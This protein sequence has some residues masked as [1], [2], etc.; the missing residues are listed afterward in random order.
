[1]AVDGAAVAGRLAGSLPFATVSFYDRS[2][3][4]AEAFGG[5][6][7]YLEETYPRVHAR[8]SREQVADLSLLYTWQGRDRSLRPALL[9]AH[10]DVVPVE[11]ASS[12][13]WVHP[14]F[15]GTIAEGFVWG[16]GALD[17]KVDVVCIL[18]AVE[19]LLAEG[20]TP[21]RTIY[22]SFG[23]DEEVGGHE[24][25]AAVAELLRSRG[26]ELAY[27]LDEGGG[28]ASDALPSLPG[29][30]A[31]IAIA[32]KGSVSIELVVEAEGGHSS[33]PPRHTA[34]GI[35]ASAIHR[36]EGNPMPASLGATTRLTL[37]YL[38]PELPF[39]GRVAVG[40]LWLFGAPLRILASRDPVLDALMRTTTAVTI[41]ESGVKANV[42]PRQAR[43]VVNHRILP[44]DSVED[45][46]TH[47]RDT[48]DD[49]R[50]SLQVGEHGE[51][52]NP[53]PVSRVDSE[54]FAVIR[55][56]V[57]E[58][59]PDVVLVPVLSVGGTDARHFYG[60]ADSVYRLT[61][62]LLSRETL[63][64]AH[65]VNER[66]PVAALA[67]AVRFYARLLRNSAGPG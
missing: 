55:R 34:A 38:A 19:A 57:A 58:V 25:A 54:A 35:L 51:P 12:A 21:E 42:V 63:Q 8:L 9:M 67:D 53:S 60:L 26:A 61:P 27:V 23:H 22:L 65:G 31:P 47:V 4:D 66:V 39:S 3:F 33:I 1:M 7:R 18:E 14:P 40:N 30:L 2:R 32:E 50:I 48:I 37:E 43:A 46:L 36:L 5:L 16:R 44:G 29:P 41:V 45:V 11:A 13:D 17:D 20:F 56:T 6:H 62:L 59:F 24:G 49:P 15:A 64:R 52:R 10:Q 28:F